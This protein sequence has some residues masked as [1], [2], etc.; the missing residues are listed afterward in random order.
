MSKDKEN[1]VVK[2]RQPRDCKNTGIYNYDIT[3]RRHLQNSQ[4]FRIEGIFH[5]L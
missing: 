5:N 1:G 4:S 2:I 3:N